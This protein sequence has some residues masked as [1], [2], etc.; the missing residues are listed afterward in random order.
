[1]STPGNFRGFRK[2]R[3][4]D[5]HT[6]ARVR[7][8]RRRDNAPRA[9]LLIA[10]RRGTAAGR[11]GT[12]TRHALADVRVVSTRG[13][14]PRRKRVASADGDPRSKRARARDRGAPAMAHDQ[15]NVAPAAEPKHTASEP[16]KKKKYVRARHSPSVPSARV[17]PAARVSRD[18]TTDPVP[19][20]AA[21]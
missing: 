19:S 9:R 17:P 3:A 4:L 18:R 8:P 21:D 20:G 12:G 5:A 7:P 10:R 16:E 14:P 15:E 11:D 13:S 1:M 6:H 2:S